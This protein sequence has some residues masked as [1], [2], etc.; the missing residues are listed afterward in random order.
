MSDVAGINIMPGS[1][2]LNLADT[3]CNWLKAN[4]PCP[5]PVA[6]SLS[7]CRR[8]SSRLS[9]LYSFALFSKAF[10]SL[11]DTSLVGAG[12]YNGQFVYFDVRKGSTPVEASPIE[13]SHR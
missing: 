5:A 7:F 2:L 12:Q 4:M 6:A 10:V 1:C 8:T 11:Q 13:R 9:I 3:F